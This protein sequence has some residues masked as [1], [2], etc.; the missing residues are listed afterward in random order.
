[1]TIRKI[2]TYRKKSH[3]RKPRFPLIFSTR[4]YFL[5]DGD[6]LTFGLGDGEGDVSGLRSVGPTLPMNGRRCPMLRITGAVRELWSCGC[7]K[8]V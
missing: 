2:P 4:Y 7:K 1:V 6:G 8:S 5:G 3:E